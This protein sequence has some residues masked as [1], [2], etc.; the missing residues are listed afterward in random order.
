MHGNLDRKIVA[1][2]AP[3]VLLTGLAG[4]IISVMMGA[5]E[6]SVSA[7]VLPPEMVG[8]KIAARAAWPFIVATLGGLP[9]LAA[10]RANTKQLDVMASFM[11]TTVFIALLAGFVPVWVRHRDAAKKW[12]QQSMKDSQEMAAAR[13]KTA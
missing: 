7:Q 1:L 4:A 6:T 10:A 12:F 3:I 2:A 11:R 9:L 13:K 8:A 5:P